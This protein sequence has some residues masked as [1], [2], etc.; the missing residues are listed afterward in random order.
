[1]QSRNWNIAVAVIFLAFSVFALGWWIPN[2]VESGVLLEER[3]SIVIGDAMAPT[4]TAIGMLVVSGALLIGALLQRPSTKAGQPIDMIERTIGISRDNFANMA[5]LLAVLVGSLVCMVWAGPLLVGALQATGYDVPNY[6][7]LTDTVPYK[8]VGF[9]LGG[10]IL[11]FGLISWITGRAAL[12]GLLTAVAAVAVL[13]I[14]YD[15][16]FDTLLLPPNGSQ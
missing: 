14:V 1:M 7:L 5:A 8:Y 10:V 2:D 3:R 9:A 15:V 6:R 11:V 13:I 4:M 16:P 12:R